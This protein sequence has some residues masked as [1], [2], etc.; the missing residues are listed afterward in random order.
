[1]LDVKNKIQKSFLD[2]VLDVTSGLKNERFLCAYIL[3]NAT[4]LSLKSRLLTN[5][6][7]S[8]QWCL[9]DARRVAEFK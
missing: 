4:W 7:K 5:V 9:V 1:M 3:I 6:C 8:G 2:F